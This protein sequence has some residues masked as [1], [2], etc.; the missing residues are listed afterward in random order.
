[1]PEASLPQ[2]FLLEQ[3]TTTCQSLF[4]SLVDV[5]KLS[6]NFLQNKAAFSD[7]IPNRAQLASSL[8]FYSG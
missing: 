2:Q 4:Y 1:M 7:L 5:I 3:L 8:G 6:K